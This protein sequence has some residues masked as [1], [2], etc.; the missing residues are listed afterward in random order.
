MCSLF[1]E[2]LRIEEIT[3]EGLDLYYEQKLT[4][5]NIAALQANVEKNLGISAAESDKGKESKPEEPGEETPAEAKKLQVDKIQ[6]N[7]ITAHVVVSGA[8]I[9]VMMIPINMEDLGT[10]PDGITAGEVFAA[11]LNKLSLGAASAAVDAS[12]QAG[13]KTMDALKDAGGKIGE[14]LGKGTDAVKGLFKK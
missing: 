1:S 6:M 3:V 8:S 10:G 14:S 12:K 9:P 7:D 5:N 13:T 2:K 4:T 11:I